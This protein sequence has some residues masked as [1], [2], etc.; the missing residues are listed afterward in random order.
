MKGKKILFLIA[1]CL[2]IPN[3]KASSCSLRASSTSVTPGT[4]ITITLSGSD[5][6]G[7]FNLSASGGSLS[8]SS[9]WIENNSQSLTFKAN[10]PGTYTIYASPLSGL[11]NNNG[12]EINVGCNS[13]KI[14]VREKSSSNS[15]QTQT[16]QKKDKRSGNNDL[17]SYGIEGQTI[18]PEFNKGTTNYTVTVPYDT[19]QIQINAFKDD[20]KATIS[21]DDG[22]KEVNPGENKFTTVVTAENGSKKSY[23]ITVIVEEKP[24]IIKIDDK[25]LELVTKEEYLPELKIEHEVMSINISDRE[26]PAYRIDSIS[27]ILVGLKDENGVVTLYKYDSFKEEEKEDEYTLYQEIESTGLNIVLKDATNVPFGYTKETIKINDTEI[28]AYKNENGFYLV[29]GLNPTTGKEGFYTYDKEENTLQRF[30]ETDFISTELLKLVFIIVALVL[31]VLLGIIVA[32]SIK[33]KQYKPKK[34]NIEK[35]KKEKNKKEKKNKKLKVTK[36]E[37]KE[38]I[39][40][41]IPKEEE[42]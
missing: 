25:E 14:T 42:K 24:I 31:S 16:T 9:V 7:R 10:S 22:F 20:D 27:Y 40:L 32:L 11:S 39:E 19:K 17:K 5:A 41:E 15:S 3:V 21:G 1:L 30:V 26:I 28:V 36:V 18:S 33:V 13:V 37:Q 23:N 6:I 12:D 35:P 34:S 38:A 4:S 2:M 8:N 29:Y